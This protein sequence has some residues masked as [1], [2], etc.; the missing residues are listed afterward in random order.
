[1][2]GGNATFTQTAGANQITGNLY[3]A[4]FS[5][6]TGTY[7]LSGGTLTLTG[8]YPESIGV[9]GSGT[10]DQ[11][12]GTN[13]FGNGSLKLGDYS[14]GNGLYSLSQSGLLT[15]SGNEYIAAAGNG[16]F[17]Q[18]GGNHSLSGSSSWLDPGYSSGDR[19]AN[20]LGNGTWTTPDTSV[21][22]NG[23]GMFTQT[24][25]TFNSSN[26]ITVGDQPGSAGTY[27]LS[28]GT[29]NGNSL[30]VGNYG[31]YDR[32]LRR[33]GNLQSDRRVGNVCRIANRRQW[34]HRRLLPQRQRIIDR[35]RKRDDRRLQ[36]G[37]RRNRQPRRQ[38][39]KFC[40]QRC[41]ADRRHSAHRCHH[42]RWKCHRSE[43]HE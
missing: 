23:A 43:Y 11:S 38:R 37:P 18:S 8:S 7:S 33:P 36:Y 10:F 15:G 34:R 27:N 25:G 19:V 30:Y 26:F 1:M 22:Y 2:P 3:V 20:P 14:G 29:I 31:R 39:G 32:L 24:G 21:G 42:K 40:R 9:S 16:T 28:G 17:I 4:S 6:D 12:G 41:A 5:S 35:H 13:N